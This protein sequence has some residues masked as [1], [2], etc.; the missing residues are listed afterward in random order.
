MTESGGNCTQRVSARADSPISGAWTPSAHQ[1]G[2]AQAVV[3]L[4]ITLPIILLLI[5]GLI[6]LGLIMHAQIVLTHAAWEGV[7]A[8]ATLDIAAG[9]GDAQIIGAA[10]RAMSGIDAS[11]VVFDIEPSE[12][13][14]AAVAWPGPRGQAISVSLQYPLTVSLPFPITLPLSAEAT[15]RIEYQNPP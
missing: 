15:S 1:Q 8:G 5:L 10:Q 13:A 14:R 6:N 12:A 4:A 7:R 2:R 11:A 9:E 3:E